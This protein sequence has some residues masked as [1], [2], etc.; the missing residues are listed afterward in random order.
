MRNCYK[1]GARVDL[2]HIVGRLSDSVLSRVCVPCCIEDWTLARSRTLREYLAQCVRSREPAEAYV[3][4]DMT[5]DDGL[6]FE[7]FREIFELA[8]EAAPQF[9]IF[10][11][12]D[13]VLHKYWPKEYRVMYT[14]EIEM[15]A[16]RRHQ[17]YMVMA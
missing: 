17:T 5:L 4:N 12:L 9:L 10:S 15:A 8:C 1:C 6:V 14:M 13:E 11:A 2:V 16:Y 3:V 7:D